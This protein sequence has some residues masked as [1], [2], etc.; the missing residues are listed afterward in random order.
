[1]TVS[2][3]AAALCGLSYLALGIVTLTGPGVPDQDWGTRGSVI[4][5]L[6]LLGFAFNVVAAER[7]RTPLRLGG[8]GLSAL[9]ASQVGLLA[10]SVESLASLISGGNTL[11]AVF[12]VGLLATLLG[13][14]V[15]GVVGLRASDTRWVALLPFLGM[16]VGVAGG[17]HGGF[18]ALG[19]VWLLFA[20]A[21]LGQHADQS[22]VSRTRSRVGL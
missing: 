21:T 4:D 7:L 18:A 12:F 11:S 9:R 15:L 8:V 13:F 6:G 20:L 1:M 10:M 17:D 14:L 19:A 5:G 3:L 22:S 2:R 16:L